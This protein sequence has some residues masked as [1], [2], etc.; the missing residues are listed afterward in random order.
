[1]TTFIGKVYKVT[2][3]HCNLI[4]IGSTKQPLSKRFSLH[5]SNARQHKTCHRCLYEHMNEVGFENFNII[6]IETFENVNREQ[7]RAHEDRF[8]CKYDTVKNGLNGRYE[9]GHI[10][11]HKKKRS[12]C[13][14]CGG[15]QICEHKRIRSAC[16]ECGGSQICEHQRERSTCKECDGGS[17]CAH[18]KRR[19]ICKECDGG[20]ICAHKRVRS[21]CKVCSGIK[22]DV[23]DVMYSNK[24]SLKRHFKTKKHIK[25]VTLIKTAK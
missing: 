10:C 11:E 23:C 5:K 3:H 17:I 22:C 12:R 4:Y 18:N 8:I 1:M 2:C 15:S 21:R 25:A 14:E 20:S 7:L 19:S 9:V 13:E 24:Y 6:L 16:K